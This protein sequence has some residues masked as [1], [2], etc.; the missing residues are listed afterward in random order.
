MR[1]GLEV[2]ICLLLAAAVLVV[3]TIAADIYKII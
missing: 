3:D 1:D 2:I